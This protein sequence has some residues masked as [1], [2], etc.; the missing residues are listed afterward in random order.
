MSVT[1][2]R[3]E[4]TAPNG[5]TLLL[6]GDEFLSSGSVVA[7]A[8]IPSDVFQNLLVYVSNFQK[9][10]VIF[11]SYSSGAEL[12]QYDECSSLVK[13]SSG[14]VGVILDKLGVILYD[15]AKSAPTVPNAFK[16]F[17]N[18][19]GGSSLPAVT[20]SDNGKVLAVVNGAWAKKLL[21]NGMKIKQ[22]EVQD[23]G[24]YVLCD[25]DVELPHSN[26]DTY[27]ALEFEYSDDIVSDFGGSSTR[28]YYFSDDSDSGATWQSLNGS[29]SV[30]MDS[31]TPAD[32][33][34]IEGHVFTWSNS[35]NYY[36]C[37]HN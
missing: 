10:S 17:T 27:D 8:G 6:K 4:R 25:G 5:I 3:I 7:T 21:S 2:A 1:F 37:P 13:D 35:D 9:V 16:P 22:L 18:A 11:K 23:W 31:L 26:F 19:G 14:K 28:R 34:T 24:D 33:I 32:T 20:G 15:S 30:L 12:T 29:H 36:S